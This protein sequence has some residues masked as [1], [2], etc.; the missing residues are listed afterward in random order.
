MTRLALHAT[1]FDK[2]PFAAIAAVTI[3]GRMTHKTCG[4]SRPLSLQRFKRIGMKGLVP[5]V[6]NLEVTYLALSCTDIRGFGMLDFL[7]TG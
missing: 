5:G 1:E 3:T 7:S 2:C 4:I 6:E